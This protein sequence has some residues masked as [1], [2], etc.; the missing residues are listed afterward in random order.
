MSDYSQYQQMQKGYYESD[1]LTPDQIVGNVPW[2][3]TFPYE[4]QLLFKYGD[5]RKPLVKDMHVKRAL[6]FACGPGRMIKRMSNYF[7]NVDGCDLSSRLLIEA[8]NRLGPDTK[9]NLYLT[10]GDDLGDVPKGRYDFVYSTIAMQHICVHSIRMKI[11]NEMNERLNKD[12]VITIQMGFTPNP[13]NET[14][15]MASWRDDHVNAQ[16][17]NSANDVAITLQDLPSVKEDFNSIFKDTTFWFYD[18]SLMWNDFDGATHPQY[19]ATHWI[20]INARKR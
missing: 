5:I 10:S 16:G 8:K 4:T 12:G 13:N 9:T 1:S 11:L 17:T 3:E 19:W 14:A 7:M 20:F 18:C 6:D 2:H 15:N